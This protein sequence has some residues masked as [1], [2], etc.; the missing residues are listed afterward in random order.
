MEK[1]QAGIRRIQIPNL[2]RQWKIS[3]SINQRYYSDIRLQTLP[4]QPYHSPIGSLTLTFGPLTMLRLA[5][6]ETVIIA[7]PVLLY[8][9]K[10]TKFE[11]THERDAEEGKYTLAL[12]VGDEVV[13]RVDADS[14]IFENLFKMFVTYQTTDIRRVVILD[15]P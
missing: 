10:L 8:G 15:K 3:F 7:H 13:G 11:L 4:D 1:L 9:D 14:M 12:S 6:E 5:Y 2:Q